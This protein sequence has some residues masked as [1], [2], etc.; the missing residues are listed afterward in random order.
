VTTRFGRSTQSPYA[1]AIVGIVVLFSPILLGRLVGLAGGV[2]FPFA[3]ALLGVGFLLEY[4]A[5]TV[6]FG[7]VALLRFDKTARP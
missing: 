5:W 4:L 1:T 3:L 7:A 6:G 2:L